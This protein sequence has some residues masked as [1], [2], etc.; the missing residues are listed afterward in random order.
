MGD[1]PQ[2]LGK[3]IKTLNNF[4]ANTIK[5]TPSNSSTETQNIK[6]SGAK[7]E[8]TL[9][10]N[11]LLDL[12]T[13]S[14]FSDYSTVRGSTN[15]EGDGR[16]IL[17]RYAN[18]LISRLTVEVGGQVVSDIAE[19]GRLNSIFMDYQFGI[20]GSSKKL[21]Q[22]VDPLK[23][24]NKANGSNLGV[25]AAAQNNNAANDAQKLVFDQFLGIMSGHVSHIDTGIVG[26]IKVT[27]YLEQPSKVLFTS[28]SFQSDGS[29]ATGTAVDPNPALAEYSLENVYATIRKISID[30]GI[31]YQSVSTALS[32]GIPFAIKYNDF[33][34]SKSGATNGNITVRAEV[35]SNSV[36]MVLL[37]FYNQNGH[38]MGKLPDENQIGDDKTKTAKELAME[39]KVNC[40]TSNYFKRVGTDITST[41]FFLNNEPI[42]LNAMKNEQV[43]KQSLIDFNIHDDTDNGIY[44]GINSLDS[45]NDN[46][47]LATCS[48][49]ALVEDSS[50]KS[51]FNCTGVNATLSATTTSSYPGGNQFIAQMYVMTSR[52]LQAFAG[53]QINIVR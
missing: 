43:F 13:F 36:D 49:S 6:S 37:T 14:V 35:M 31:Y 30:D 29:A 9:P 46:Y 19:Y 32:S 18:S 15:A 22:N 42:P 26:N 8:F 28:G 44:Y 47:W 48:L 23:R 39:G 11:S 20:E 52:E 12:S 5:L 34:E 24:I 4:S 16:F 45:W 3:R 41:Q 2:N 17:A 51:G 7:L 27:I 25:I 33:T 50:W 40:F 1:Y 21:C 53:R 38:V 10:P